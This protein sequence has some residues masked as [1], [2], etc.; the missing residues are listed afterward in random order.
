VTDGDVAVATLD[1]LLL[2]SGT[3]PGC[4]LISL[5]DPVVARA[6]QVLLV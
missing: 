6:V 3:E 4:A 2:T 5:P 1:V